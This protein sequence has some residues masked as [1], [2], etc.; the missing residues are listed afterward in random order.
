[1]MIC[2]LA[3]WHIFR[4][5]FS[6]FSVSFSF[7][8][9]NFAYYCVVLLNAPPN[10]RDKKKRKTNKKKQKRV[11]NGSLF[12][13]NLDPSSLTPGSLAVLLVCGFMRRDNRVVQQEDGNVIT[14]RESAR[15]V[16]TLFRLPFSPT[17]SGRHHAGFPVAIKTPG[18]CV[19]FALIKEIMLF[20]IIAELISRITWSLSLVYSVYF[21]K[22]Y[23]FIYAKFP[24]GNKIVGKRRIQDF[25][26]RHTCY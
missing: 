14:E 22:I 3:S 19:N 24:K 15:I 6:I 23:R 12:P 18:I 1:M 11:C 10:D 26:T 4:F 7:A 25:R 13:G 20:G 8:F 2:Y 9:G 21:G 5:F 17:S 16:W